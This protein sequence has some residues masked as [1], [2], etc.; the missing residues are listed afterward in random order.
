MADQ[1]HTSDDGD[2]GSSG[3]QSGELLGAMSPKPRTLRAIVIGLKKEGYSWKQIL[4]ALSGFGWSTDAIKNAMHAV[5][6]EEGA[7]EST[8]DSIPDD[9]VEKML[10]E[11]DKTGEDEIPESPEDILDLLSVA[12]V[13]GLAL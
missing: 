11:L 5:G 2:N 6:L 8:F 9:E 10:A 3:E 7:V 13:G 4:N 1:N 12:S